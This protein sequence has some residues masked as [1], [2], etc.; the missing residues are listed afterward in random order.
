MQH[1][2]KRPLHLRVTQPREVSF[3]TT[4]SSFHA[5]HKRETLHGITLVDYHALW[6]QVWAVKYVPRLVSLPLLL[7]AAVEHLVALYLL[8]GLLL[9][10]RTMPYLPVHTSKPCTPHAYTTYY[11]CKHMVHRRCIITHGTGLLQKMQHAAEGGP[12]Y[13]YNTARRMLDDSMLCYALLCSA[14]IACATNT[15][16][17]AR[18]SVC[19]SVPLW[20]RPCRSVGRP[21][22]IKSSFV[23]LSRCGRRHGPDAGLRERAPQDGGG[24]AGA[25]GGN[26]VRWADGRSQDVLHV[27]RPPR[28]PRYHPVRTGLSLPPHR[29]CPLPCTHPHGL[30]V[31]QLV[32]CCCFSLVCVGRKCIKWKQE[33]VLYICIFA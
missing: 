24:A 17:P 21:H 28:P 8:G 27:G 18:L 5:A 15:H 30:G 1:N 12:L 11:T 23:L 29:A 2:N 3:V 32:C 4:D 16:P 20:A 13:F 26:V 10:R 22:P 33:T 9:P 19:L 25:R 31:R 6:K 14:I 7:A